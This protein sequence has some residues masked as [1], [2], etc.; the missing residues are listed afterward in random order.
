MVT[1]TNMLVALVAVAATG[2]AARKKDCTPNGKLFC[3]YH[4]NDGEFGYTRE[5]LQAAI[6]S[7]DDVIVFNSLYHCSNAGTIVGGSFCTGGA[8]HCQ[9]GTPN[10][11]CS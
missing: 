3:G 9:Q 4:L 1:I 2:V 11:F 7:T 8:G 5:E 10:D 6:Q